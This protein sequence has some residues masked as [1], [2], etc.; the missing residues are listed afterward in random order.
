VSYQRFS[1]IAAIFAS[2]L[3]PCAT[4]A[5]S[6]AAHVTRQQF[7]QL[8][9]I[10]GSWRGGGGA[11]PAF[12]EEY[13]VIDDSTLQMRAYSDSTFR[14]ATDSSTIEW[15]TASVQSRSARSTYVAIELAPTSVRFIRPGMTSGGH[16]FARV[17]ADE[18]T[19]TLHPSAP[20]GRATVYTMRRRRR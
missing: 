8:Q 10:V 7:H 13:R 11:Y 9:W 18:W 20:G 2:L 17:S 15:R 6:P 16:T 14:V 19:A 3:R 5:Q 12:F 4:Q 1:L